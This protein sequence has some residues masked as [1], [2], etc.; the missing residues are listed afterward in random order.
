[1]TQQPPAPPAP[2]S[3]PTPPG[4]YG[5]PP[6]GYGPPPGGYGPP[7]GGYGPSPGGY[8][9]PPAPHPTGER[10]PTP[11]WAAVLAV[12]GVVVVVGLVAT[13]LTALVLEAATRTDE[14]A[15]QEQGVA[16]VRIT[17]VTGGANI[18]TDED[19]DGDVTGTARA[20]TSWQEAE[21][22]VERRGDV[23]LLD[24]RCPDEGWPRRC[25]IGYDLVVDPDTDVVVDI[26][27][28]GLR[29]DGLAGDVDVSVTAGGVLLT[30][31]TSGTV[32]A[33]V[34]TGGVVLSFD[35]PPDEVRVNAATG[36][37]G[38]DV[39]DDGT[40]YDVRTSVSVGN[41]SVGV[42][43]EDGAA[44]SIEASTRVGGIEIDAGPSSREAD[45]DWRRWQD[46]G[47]DHTP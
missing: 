6:G 35:A 17:G 23:L 13:A 9:P 1:M 5:P 12:L 40:A 15:I 24:A 29:A 31:L 41:A 8:G 18:E 10:P 14:V 28:G 44:R 33:D 19:A 25:E 16:E 46:E 39:P 7:P 34:T 32:V 21:V 3:P 22:T 43:T 47:R 37:I 38:I 27:T 4:G 20:T 2:P 42:P 26:V 30:S 45:Q 11:W 36:G